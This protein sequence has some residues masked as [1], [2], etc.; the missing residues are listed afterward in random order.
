MPK[1]IRTIV[2]QPIAAARFNQAVQEHPYFEEFWV[3]G[4][5]WWVARK[6]LVG[7]RVPGL[8]NK[9]AT[10]T[11]PIPRRG[12]PAVRLLYSVTDNEVV[13]ESMAIYEDEPDKRPSPESVI[14][15]MLSTP[16]KK[17]D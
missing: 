8:H 2:E 10:E 5:S 9:F 12:I 1:K 14:K 15:H 16:P 13:I 17:K 3:K 11:R 6:P 7:K 4:L